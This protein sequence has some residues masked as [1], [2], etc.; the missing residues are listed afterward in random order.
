ME[1]ILIK[2]AQL[3]LSLSILIVLH[4]LGHFLPA[5]WFGIKVE[6]FYLFFD[7]WFSLIKKKIGDTT[8]GIGWLPLGGYVKI[9]GMID[10]SMDKEQM[11]KPAEPWEFRSKPA[12][13]RLIVMVG[14]VTVNVLLAIFIY[15]MIL[16]QWGNNQLHVDEL[17]YG[18]VPAPIVQDEI[19]IIPGDKIVK[20]EGKEVT[21]Y[22]DLRT[23]LIIETPENV[24]VERNGELIDLP[25]TMTSLGK[26]IKSKVPVVAPRIPFDISGVG[27]GSE[28]EKMGFKEGDQIVALN[29]T[30]TRFFDEFEA[31]KFKL[32]AGD[33]VTVDVKRD[34]NTVQLNGT[35]PEDQILGVAPVAD[36]TKYFNVEHIDYGFF[37]SFPAGIAMAID[38]LE[39]FVKQ[40]KFVFS[41]EAEGYKQVGGILAIGQI[42]PAQWD[43]LSFWNLTAFLSIMLAFLNILPIPA[44]DGGHV[45]FLLW[46]VITGKK[47]SQKLLERS[48]VIGMVLLL[49]LFVLVNGNDVYKIITGAG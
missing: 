7:P 15:A 19:G 29:G 26:I 39:L 33:A 13:Q 42:F 40:F 48:Q 10:E 20:L 21:D 27:E 30:S 18:V 31:E 37:E 43:W 23:D 3:I 36:L 1:V 22:F 2:A 17:K 46:E 8:Y 14:G 28:A 9:A 4:E 34:G 25:V 38:K 32:S 44:L 6:K 12:W 16:N 24:T 35:L 45:M 5:K 41:K 47:P 49:T 11:A